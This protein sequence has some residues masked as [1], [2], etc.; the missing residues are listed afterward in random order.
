MA[1]DEPRTTDHIYEIAGFQYIV[2]KAFMEKVKPVKIDFLPVGFKITAGI[3][4]GAACGSSCDTKGSCCSGQ[5][6]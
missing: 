4:F 3:D 1:L 6:K 2:D 5:G